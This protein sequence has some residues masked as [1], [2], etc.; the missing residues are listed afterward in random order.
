MSRVPRFFAVLTALATLIV[1]V[2]S[3]VA[4]FAPFPDVGDLIGVTF[5]W[6][7]FSGFCWF[8]TWLWIDA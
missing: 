2:L 1:F 6:G 7:L 5:I 4:I 3:Y 8:L